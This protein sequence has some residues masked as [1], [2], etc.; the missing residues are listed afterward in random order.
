MPNKK[1]IELYELN[2][3]YTHETMKRTCALCSVDLTINKGE[4]IAIIG[5][6][7]SGKSTLLRILRGE[8]YPD[9]VNGGTIIWYENSNKPDTSPLAGRAITSL[10]SP[11]TQEYYATQAWNVNC[12]EIILAAKTNDYILYKN[13]TQEEIEEVTKIASLLNAEHLL[14]SKISILS[15]GQL[16]IILIARAL[17]RKAPILLLDEATNGLDVHSQELV[18]KALSS[19]VKEK[20]K[21]IPLPTIVMTSHRLPLPN[22]IKKTYSM[23]QG[24]LSLLKPETL[25]NPQFFLLD[26]VEN[27]QKHL[28]KSFTSI[29]NSK[30]PKNEYQH[31]LHICLKNASA[32]I[33]HKEILHNI[34]WEIK[35]GEQWAVKGENGSGKSTLL[36]VILGFIPVAL[37][38]SI[39]RTFYDSTYSKGLLLTELSTI[40]QHVRLVSDALQTHYTY[41][42]TVEDIVFCGLDG[43]IGV[44]RHP[45]EEEMCQVENCIEN[46]NLKA[47][48]KRK[49]HSLSTGQARR[50]LLARAIIGSPSLLLLDEPFSGLDFS[51]RTELTNCIEN[52]ILKGV[53]TIL[54]SHHEEDFLPSTSHVAHMQY[55]YLQF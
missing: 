29:P 55:G 5:K 45:S 27:P 31:S 49:L 44:Y 16:R 37:G 8:I 21:N 52:Q 9:Q 51:S 4:H 42:D 11:K 14:Q 17:I 53:Q 10:V 43:N 3:H 15:Q 50:T 2:V 46:F 22:F 23:N 48:R 25:I 47:L 20:N 41:N 12:L 24:I 13:P 36:K 18:L 39:T 54:V 33:D 30:L 7:G 1:L 19:L 26:H 6:N 32:Y 35:K 34:T 28:K 38:G 40:K